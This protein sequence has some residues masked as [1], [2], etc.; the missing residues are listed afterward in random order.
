MFRVSLTE[1][2][3]CHILDFPRSFPNRSLTGMTYALI[4]KQH[5]ERQN[6]SDFTIKQCKEFTHGFGTITSEAWALNIS[7]F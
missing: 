1:R 3:L 5:T 7:L 6:V 4:R 2:N